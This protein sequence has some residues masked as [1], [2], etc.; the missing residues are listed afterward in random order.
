MGYARGIQ[1]DGGAVAPIASTLY[2]TCATAAATAAKVVALADFDQLVTGVTVHV[3]FT[4]A[5]TAANPTL[6]INST[7]AKPIMCYG[8]TTPGT[9]DVT[10]WQAGSVVSF[11]YDGTN[12]VMNDWS[13]NDITP[14][15]SEEIDNICV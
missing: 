8:S 10:S 2:G 5:N 12:F 15:T 7:G 13:N 9:S 11:T 6:N 14:I 1:I 3:K 4:Y